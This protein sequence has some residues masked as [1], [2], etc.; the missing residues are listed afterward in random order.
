MT[1][2]P[3]KLPESAEE[4][5]LLGGAFQDINLLDEF[6]EGGKGEATKSSKEEKII[7]PS[8]LLNQQLSSLNAFGGIEDSSKPTLTPTPTSS[9]V[10]SMFQVC[11]L[12]GNSSI[13]TWHCHKVQNIVDI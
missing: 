10:F 9:N 13:R 11:T 8:Q 1:T 12:I 3:D 7:L 2:K 6:G 5:D 4:P